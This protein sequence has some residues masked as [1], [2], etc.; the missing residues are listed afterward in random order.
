MTAHAELGAGNADDDLVLH[1]Q[2]GAPVLV[3]PF[4]G[5]PL[6]AFQILLAGLGVERD[7]RRVGL[8]QEDLAVG[9]GERRG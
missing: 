5:S 3:S 7:E 9:I 1:R 4:F 2:H 8:M 6:T